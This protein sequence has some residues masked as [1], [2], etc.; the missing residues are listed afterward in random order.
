M[1]SEDAICL[2]PI[3][4][5]KLEDKNSVFVDWDEKFLVSFGLLLP[6]NKRKIALQIFK[7]LKDFKERNILPTVKLISLELEEKY[8]LKLSER[9]ILYHLGKFEN[10]GLIEW[11]GN[12]IL[13]ALKKKVIRESIIHKVDETLDILFGDRDEF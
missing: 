13:F 12:R 8:G 11:K 1:D 2:R 7:I 9:L 4:K 3:K 10:I 5:Y 6:N